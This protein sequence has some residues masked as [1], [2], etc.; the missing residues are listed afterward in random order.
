MKPCGRPRLVRGR[1]ATQL[2]DRTRGWVMALAG[3]H[4]VLVIFA[5]LVMLV[6]PRPW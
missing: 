1:E 6:M 3:L 2:V 5:V 4:E